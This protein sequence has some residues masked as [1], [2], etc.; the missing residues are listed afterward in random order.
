MARDCADGKFEVIYQTDSK[1]ERRHQG[2][3][4]SSPLPESLS[5]IWAKHTDATSDSDPGEITLS[6][7]ED[8]SDGPPSSR[9]PSRPRPATHISSKVNQIGTITKAL[10]AAKDEFGAEWGV[11]VSHRSGVTEDVTISDIVVGLR[12][13]Q[14]ETGAPAQ[15]ERLAKLNQILRTGEELGDKAVYAGTNFRTSVNM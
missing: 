13:G 5:R 9:W 15:S 2:G 8:Y 11:M 14:I 1:L 6:D 12:V 10:Q 4:V 7:N 3:L